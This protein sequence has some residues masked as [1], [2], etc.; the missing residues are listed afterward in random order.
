MKAAKRKI[1]SQRDVNLRLL[2]FHFFC[3]RAPL[4]FG[5]LTFH[6]YTEI[7]YFTYVYIWQIKFKINDF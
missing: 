4:T 7:H 6:N 3:F 2:V 1:N 5:P